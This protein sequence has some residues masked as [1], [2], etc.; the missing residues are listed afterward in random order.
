MLL[1]IG[2]AVVTSGLLY[3]RVKTY[4][5]NKKKKERPW[6]WHAERLRRTENENPLIKSIAKGAQFDKKTDSVISFTSNGMARVTE[7]L[8]LHKLGFL[9]KHRQQ[10]E[11]M[12]GG[13][14]DIVSPAEKRTNQAFS[15]A[16]VNLGIVGMSLF[17]PPIVWLAVP[18]MIINSMHFY[19][20]AYNA[21]FKEHRISSYVL[22]ALA[23]SGALIGQYFYAVAVLNWAGMLGR[24][25]LLQS[26]N[27]TKSNLSNLF[28]EQP[29]SVWVL[30]HDEVEVE[31]PFEA[32][33]SGDTIIVSA[34]QMIPV[35]G[36]IERGAAKIDQHKLTGESQPIEKG[37][38]EPV[39]AS[40]LVLA[41]KLYIQVEKTGHQTVAMQIGQLLEE[42]A[43]FKN[44]VQSRGEVIADGLVL[45]TLGL[46]L[47]TFSLLG[48]NSGLAVLCNKFGYKLRI[49]APASML[50]FLD[51]A[52]QEG[53]LIKDG[54]S[55]ELLN[56][57]DTIVFDKT[58]TL[59][60]EQPTVGTIHTCN[61]VSENE[62]L[63]YTAAA[64]QGQT[65]PIAKAIL[66]AANERLLSWPQTLDARYEIGY[67]VKVELPD[68]VIRVGSNKFMSME[69]ITIPP[70]MTQAQQD[71]HEQGHSLIMVAFDKQLVG[72][73][74]LHATI[75]PEA[76]RV[77]NTLRQRHIEM[78]IISGDHEQPTKKLAQSL[79][80]DHYFANTLPE[81]K[82]QL[83]E[84]LREEG[85]SICFIG[86]GIN[87]TIA[88][89]KANVSV[90]LS[91][92]TTIATDTA[93]VVLMDGTLNQLP[94]LFDMAQEFN[95]NM[96]N[97]LIIA[98]VPTMIGL[99]GVFF[100]HWGF[101]S[102]IVLSQISGLLGI[103]NT[104]YPLLKQKRRKREQD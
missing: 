69:G 66:T 44:S 55:L 93:Q 45:P 72:A 103:G 7:I 70:E 83:V 48:L 57:I 61:G 104:M 90:S 101:F 15:I 58:G 67:G 10:M 77:I 17:Y 49:Y 31:I 94:Y 32:L 14:Y 9:S 80:I 91:G 82:A 18:G 65:H 40:T 25:L 28:G 11:D 22:D 59:T 42:T 87:D 99:G 8:H 20:L 41:G 13:R 102:V 51:I 39:L 6:T 29:R 27:N 36:I 63:R 19:K 81:N 64:E 71:S 88:L 33:H 4:Q 60:L 96:R 50:T 79:G 23:V 37:V 43:D 52:T 68:R 24:K 86:D 47:V 85:K 54:R 92:A 12:A 1:T 75:R 97:N 38:G 35:D 73:I 30:T 95:L 74:E 34:G 98:T 100:F 84:Q 5:E 78:Y 21:L 89:K 26:E 56:Q 46:S 2:T 62:I 76:K 3:Q 53:I 16:S